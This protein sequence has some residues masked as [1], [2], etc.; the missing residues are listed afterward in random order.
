MLF[1][2]SFVSVPANRRGRD[3]CI[4]DLHGCREMLE[5]LL[6]AVEFNQVRDRLFSVGDLIH[7]GPNSAQCLRLAEKDWFFPV[8][9]NHEAMQLGAYRG[10]IHS[11]GHPLSSMC[12]FAGSDDPLRPGRADQPQLEAILERLPLA[13]EVPLRSGARVGIVHA[14][15]PGE[16]SWDDIR[17][18]TAP[19]KILYE[20]GLPGIQTAI[21]W[22][23]R[24]MMAA[25]AALFFTNETEM[26][27]MYPLAQ[28]HQIRQMTKIVDGVDL[29][30]SGH[31]T[32]RSQPLAVG[33]RRYIDRGAG[34][35]DGALVL[36]ELGAEH[37]WEV[38]DPRCNPDMPV[39]RYES[40]QFARHCL[41]WLSNDEMAG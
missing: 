26:H 2:S 13:I 7:R 39:S 31:T 29:L 24:L 27:S 8:M 14:G 17:A 11:S 33:N 15:L 34:M 6:Q 16:W 36:M 23:R 28:R 32:L 12:E 1:D 19:E 41:P 21:L 3:F 5:R 4:G 18:L 30:V 38:T 20:K 37:Y 10:A 22:D 25:I 35:R 9:G 40:F